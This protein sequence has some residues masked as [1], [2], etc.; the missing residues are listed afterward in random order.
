MNRHEVINDF[1]FAHNIKNNRNNVTGNTWTCSIFVFD[2][3]ILIVP[4]R[5]LLKI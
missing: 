5:Y 1:D 3:F 4:P 2:S